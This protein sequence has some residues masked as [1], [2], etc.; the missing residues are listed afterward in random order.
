MLY[1]F[2]DEVLSVYRSG[3][4]VRNNTLLSPTCTFCEFLLKTKISRIKDL[5]IWPYPKTAPVVLQAED[6]ARLNSVSVLE[7]IKLT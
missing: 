3:L 4:K 7:T 2:I 5:K 1:E 6:S